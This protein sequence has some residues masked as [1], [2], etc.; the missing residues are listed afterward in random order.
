MGIERKDAR[1]WMRLSGLGFELA[2]SIAGGAFLGWWIDR[3]FG[4]TPKA[5]IALTAIGV[6]G[7]FYNLIRTALAATPPKPPEDQGR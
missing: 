4:T 2:A 5:L 1:A 3:R 7:G 6:V